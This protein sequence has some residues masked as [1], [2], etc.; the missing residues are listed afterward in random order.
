MSPRR[1]TPGVRDRLVETAARILDGEGRQAVSA[2]RVAAEAGVSTMAV[3][4]HVGSMDELLAAV[5]REGYR[6]FTVALTTAGESADPVADWMAQGWAYRR[7]A[8]RYPHLYRTMFGPGVFGS[9]LRSPEDL[10]ES[11]A[12]FGALLTMLERCREAGRFAYRDPQVA[13]ERVWAA[14]H[15]MVSLELNDYFAGFGRD[16]VPSYEDVLIGLAAGF[17]DGD[18]A[19][20]TS[21]RKARTRARKADQAG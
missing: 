12:A 21:L 3:Y 9:D 6:R 4:S 8:L 10:V 17:G 15:G 18:G 1:P 20:R 14:V 11:A 19:I 16:P 13:G 2:R 7:F 5:W